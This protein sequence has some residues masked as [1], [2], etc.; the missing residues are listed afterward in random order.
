MQKM[1]ENRQKQIE[2]VKQTKRPDFKNPGIDNY[3][4]DF[5]ALYTKLENAA[6]AEEAN[7]LN[8]KYMQLTTRMA[9][10]IKQLNNNQVY[11]FSKY[12]AKLSMQWHDKIQVFWKD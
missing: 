5:D 11:E 7:A 1:E 8:E 6:S 10:I 9:D 2:D 3:F 4:D 12:N